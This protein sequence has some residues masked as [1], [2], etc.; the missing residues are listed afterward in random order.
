L[1]DVKVV[2]LGPYSTGAKVSTSLNP[3]TT[4]IGTT[5]TIAPTLPSHVGKSVIKIQLTKVMYF[6]VYSFTITVLNVISSIIYFSPSLA[7]QIASVSSPGI[8]PLPSITNT[9]NLPVTVTCT[10]PASF[11]TYDSG[12]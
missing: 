9:A 6:T 7:D 8:Y 1:N 10:I 4:F 5:L 3:Y 12:K 11:I 2:D